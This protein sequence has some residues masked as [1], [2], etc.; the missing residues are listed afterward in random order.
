[1][2]P[3]PFNRW[4]KRSIEDLLLTQRQFAKRCRLSSGYV[5]RL[6]TGAERP[7]RGLV[8]AKLAR[9]L[10][11]ERSVVEEQLLTRARRRAA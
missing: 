6:V 5:S 7:S 10:G 8:V 2:C 3:L 1:M 11:V 4:L 9:G